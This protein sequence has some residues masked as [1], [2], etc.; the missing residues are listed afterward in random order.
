MNLFY[1]FIAESAT[2]E[3]PTIRNPIFT[4]SNDAENTTTT[5]TDSLTSSEVEVR[6][7]TRS[8]PLSTT[9][10]DSSALVN[11]S[12]PRD[13]LIFII[14]IVAGVGIGTIALL[15]IVV[16]CIGLVGI[17]KCMQA[18]S[19]K[20]RQSGIEQ[21]EVV[22]SSSNGTLLQENTAY[23]KLMSSWSTDTTGSGYETLSTEEGRNCD[24]E[25]LQNTSSSN[26]NAAGCETTSTEEQPEPES[27]QPQESS[28]SS[29]IVVQENT[30]YK[31]S[32]NS[33]EIVGYDTTLTVEI[34]DTNLNRCA[35]STGIAVYKNTAYKKSTN[36][37]DA[38]MGYETMDEIVEQ[39][40]Q[41]NQAYG[42]QGEA[43]KEMESMDAGD[44]EMMTGDSVYDFGNQIHREVDK[45]TT[46]AETVTYDV[47]IQQQH[48]NPEDSEHSYDYVI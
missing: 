3:E 30:A 32:T 21:P 26:G 34:Q 20:E 19:A 15:G 17:M 8:N 23:R 40:M 46:L 7:T 18:R 39:V 43:Q 5:V 35:N 48:T 16:T 14:H 44:Y 1:I 33:G 25:Q 42:F 45:N 41:L 47:L 31:K 36:S 28:D 24:A 11:T 2:S 12:E 13:E 38:V 6:T 37:E 4:A 9:T 29:G 10:D 27:T 22:I